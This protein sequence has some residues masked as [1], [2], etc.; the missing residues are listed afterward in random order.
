MDIKTPCISQA[1]KVRN[2][3]ATFPTFSYI[4]HIMIA[5]LHNSLSDST[6]K[7]LFL[8]RINLLYLYCLHLQDLIHKFRYCSY[9]SAAHLH[10]RYLFNGLNT[11][12]PQSA[13]ISNVLQKGHS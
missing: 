3:L 8:R 2:F 12:Q 13:F 5:I 7:Q 9:K 11:N 10:F 4:Y 6:P 1:T